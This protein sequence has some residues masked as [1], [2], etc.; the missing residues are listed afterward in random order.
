MIDPDPTPRPADR[1]IFGRVPKDRPDWSHRRGEPRGLVLAWAVYLMLAAAAVLGGATLAGGISLESYR[2]AAGRLMVLLALGSTVLWPMLR[3]SQVAPRAHLAGSLLLDIL[4]LT[5]PMQ[6]LVWMQGMMASWPV[7]VCGAVSVVL[8]GW[9]LIGGALAMV[10]VTL[11]SGLA[12]GGAMA[13][14]LSMVVT[15]LFLRATT[16]DDAWLW[17]S[18]PGAVGFMTRDPTWSDG[19]LPAL[20]P[21]G[22]R[23]AAWTAIAGLSA[24]ALALS[25]RLVRPS[26][27]A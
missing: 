8:L 11:G 10:G 24:W 9:M 25:V 7:S 14:L 27:V 23:A 5:A 13:L 16:G 1:D 19:R 4:I 22:P 21:G 18:P 2:I 20:P 6:L 12:R 26:A 15:P 17:W 3:L